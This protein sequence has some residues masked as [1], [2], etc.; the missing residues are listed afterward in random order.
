LAGKAAVAA[1]AQRWLQQH[2]CDLVSL[3]IVM[4]GGSGLPLADA[5]RRQ[6][7]APALAFVSA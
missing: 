1:E 5:I 7:A 6:P 2:P 3:D 4:H